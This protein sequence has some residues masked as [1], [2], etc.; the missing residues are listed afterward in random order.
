MNGES[1]VRAGDEIL[2][3]VAWFYYKDELTQEKIARLLSVSRA[4]VGRMLERARK[5]GLVTIQLNSA[6]LASM[7]LSSKL[8]SV[9]GLDDA[10]VI[11][12]LEDSAVNNRIGLGGA[13]LL[14]TLLKG[15]TNLGIGFGQTV[16]QVVSA[17]DFNQTG[18]VR[19]VT[20]TGGVDGYL[21]PL[22]W[23]R[24]NVDE[25]E[26]TK[27]FVIPSPIVTSTPQLAESLRVEPTIE[28]VLKRARAVDIAVVGVGTPDRDSTIVEMGYLS[29]DDVA[30]L[31]ERGVVGD[32]LGQF[33]DASGQVVTLPIHDRRIGI[34]L[35][36]LKLIP[37]VIGV[38][39]GIHKSEAIFAALQGNYLDALV[40]DQAV[41]MRLLELAGHGHR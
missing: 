23:S 41:A 1:E 8:R 30:L 6:Y 29:V 10:I 24:A 9:F 40:T 17:T 14:S 16:S 4:S 26:P 33:F 21:H 3:R 12:D 18:N 11:P 36:E 32:I 28:A 5:A 25:K 35:S 39:G 38:A 22:V 27:A 13:Q 19:L 15:E 37:R 34:D 20:L 31:L 2:L 7:E